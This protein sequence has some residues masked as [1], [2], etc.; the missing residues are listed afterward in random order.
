MT[1]D[2][3]LFTHKHPIVLFHINLFC[4]FEIIKTKIQILKMKVTN[5]FVNKLLV[6]QKVTRAR[7]V[8]FYISFPYF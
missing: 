6:S 2:L 8:Y 1:H 4:L 7:K 3:V 5:E